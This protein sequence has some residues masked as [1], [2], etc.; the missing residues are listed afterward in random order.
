VAEMGTDMTRFPTAAHFASWA[1]T[2]PGN[3]ESA[4]K[5]QS[6][7]TRSGKKWLKATLVEAAQAVAHTRGTYLAAHGHEG[8]SGTHCVQV[9]AGSF[10]RDLD[11]LLAG[12]RPFPRRPQPHAV[13]LV[14]SGLRHSKAATRA[15]SRTCQ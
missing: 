7:K 1:G 14:A 12:R 2:C 15:A 11:I 4:C 8:G 5:Q 9:A 3:H 10:G 6:G 13:R